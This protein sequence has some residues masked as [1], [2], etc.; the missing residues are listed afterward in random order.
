VITVQNVELWGKDGRM[1]IALDLAGSL[2]GT[3]YLS[4]IP[5][6]DAVSKEI[7]FEDM[8]YVLNTKGILTKTANWLLQGYILRKIQAQCRYSI[9]PNMEE[10]K[11]N[12]L[13]YLNNYSPMKGVFVNGSILELD[14]DKIELTDD[15]I[16]AFINGSGKMNVRVDGMD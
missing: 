16:I 11:K 9:Q 4:G 1:I 13:P 15:Y 7:Y 6:Y 2:N 5:K 3:I 8:D 14:F 12:L 10:G